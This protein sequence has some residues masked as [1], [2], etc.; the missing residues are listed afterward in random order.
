MG[1]Y[2]PVLCA[3]FACSKISKR[4]EL[5]LCISCLRLYPANVR[6]ETSRSTL[7]RGK[8]G[9]KGE[10]PCRTAGRTWLTAKRWEFQTPT[11][12]KMGI[13]R[14]PQPPPLVTSLLTSFWYTVRWLHCEPLLS[15]EKRIKATLNYICW[16][17]CNINHIL[18]SFDLSMVYWATTSV[19]R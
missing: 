9:V 4:S 15:P 13:S 12:P 16:I 14:G 8:G 1:Q 18:A 17:S 11:R 3:R 19:T 2:I 5:M 7:F 10:L 6:L